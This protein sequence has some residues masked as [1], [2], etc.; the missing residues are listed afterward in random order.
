M[1]PLTKH[2][3]LVVT[4]AIV[5][6]STFADEQITP[7]PDSWPFLH[8]HSH[9]YWWI[10]PLTMFVLFILFIFIFSRN[11]GG[12]CRPTWWREDDQNTKIESALDILNKRYARGE[13]EKEEYEDKKDS[14][15][16]TNS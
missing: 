6:F 13:I 16:S 2:L 11:R 9:G 4:L 5:S 15:I 8:S 14:I 10:F 1:R 7:H 12:W 3:S